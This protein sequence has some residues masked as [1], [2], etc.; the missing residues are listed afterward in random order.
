MEKNYQ[1]Q[2]AA[3]MTVPD[4]VAITGNVQAGSS[5]W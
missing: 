5:S 2:T 4:S 1:T 3:A